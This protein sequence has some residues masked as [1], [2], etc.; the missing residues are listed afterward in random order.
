MSIII[1]PL[2]Q[3][4]LIG[5]LNWSIKSWENKIKSSACKI[6]KLRKFRSWQ[7]MLSKHCVISLLICASFICL[8]VMLVLFVYWL[9]DWYSFSIIENFTII[10]SKCL[11]I[12]RFL[13]SNSL[14]IDESKE[15][16]Q[17]WPLFSNSKW[18]PMRLEEQL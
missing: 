1:K 10:F 2:W 4:L 9:G 11:L 5:N 12:E 8:I 6:K 17:V 13:H 18:M 15:A 14:V 7:L 16:Y 3:P